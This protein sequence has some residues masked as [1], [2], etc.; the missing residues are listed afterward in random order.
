MRELLKASW[1]C[2]FNSSN[3]NSSN[4]NRIRMNNLNTHYAS[5]ATLR[6]LCAF[7]KL[8]KQLILLRIYLKLSS[9]QNVSSH[10]QKE[11]QF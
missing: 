2:P 7:N 10:T 1:K 3:H 4:I 6:V 8:I 9:I 5:G 11:K